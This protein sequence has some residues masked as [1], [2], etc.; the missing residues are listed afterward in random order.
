MLYIF[1]AVAFSVAVSILLKLARRAGIDIVQAVGANY[2]VA[3]A[4]AWW[5][6]HATPQAALDA[7]ATWTPLIVLGILLPSIFVI[8]ARSVRT[9]GIVRTDVAQRLSLFVSLIAAFA[10]LGDTLTPI[11]GVGIGIALVAVLCVLWRSERG[12]VEAGSWWAPLLVFAGFGAIDICFKLIAQAGASFPSALLAAFLIAMVLCWLVA[13][14]RAITG[15]AALSLR[16]LAF[17]A[18]LGACNFANILFYIKGHQA[19]ANDP[20]LVFASTN[21]GVV[22]LGTLVGAFGFREKL[23]A[24][25]WVGIAL[26]IVAIGVMTQAR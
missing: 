11:K 17:G 26:A 16:N 12:R 25:N 23:S 13:L 22:V 15:A 1:L 8:M 5:L 2:I 24:L 18:V 10:F 21:A 20:S 9:V 19:L 4:M 14:G 6:L 3:S 7:R